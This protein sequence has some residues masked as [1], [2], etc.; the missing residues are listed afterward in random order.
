MLRVSPDEVNQVSVELMS[1]IAVGNVAAFGELV[2]LH[3]AAV[4]GTAFRM[5]GNH[6]DAQDLSQQVFL[7]IWKAA[8]RYVPTAKF[9]TWMFTILRNCAAT[10]MRKRGRFMVESLDEQR[11]LHGFEPMDAQQRSAGDQ[12]AEKE[13]FAHIHEAVQALPDQQKLAMSLRV[14]EELSYEEVAEVMETSVSAVKSLI[15]RARSSLKAAF[16]DLDERKMD[17]NRS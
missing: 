9:S 4:V 1:R 17:R 16:E 10:C 13:E 11:E 7:R 15:F 5:C 2:A 14:Y 8:A 3:Q 12:L 6:E